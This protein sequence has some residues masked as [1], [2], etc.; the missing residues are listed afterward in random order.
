M[1]T[2]KL[3]RKIHIQYVPTA[4]NNGTC[5]MHAESV[6]PTE[7]LPGTKYELVGLVG[8]SKSYQPTFDLRAKIIV[9]RWYVYVVNGKDLIDTTQ[10]ATSH[11][12]SM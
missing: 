3:P 5:A 8:C 2:A 7:L 4:P 11:D 12:W 10:R 6:S 9:D 1:L